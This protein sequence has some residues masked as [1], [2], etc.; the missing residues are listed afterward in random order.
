MPVKK[1][2]N[3]T[4][5]IKVAAAIEAEL[6]RMI[7]TN[8]CT[9]LNVKATDE[10]YFLVMTRI[11]YSHFLA[12]GEPIFP[13]FRSMDI[14]SCTMVPQM[15]LAVSIMTHFKLPILEKLGVRPE[16]VDEIPEEI[17]AIV[18]NECLHWLANQ[19]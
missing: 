15:V 7:W 12:D 18:R 6:G 2:K 8:L 17:I 19:N 11:H 4:P 9:F 5:D 13:P 16:D 10:D 1:K 3:L 14:A